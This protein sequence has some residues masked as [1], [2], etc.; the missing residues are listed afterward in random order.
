MVSPRTFPLFLLPYPS[1]LNPFQHESPT[2]GD[3]NVLSS[4][5]F[6]YGSSLHRRYQ[7]ITP[8]YQSTD[9]CIVLVLSV[10][11]PYF[12]PS[13]SRRDLSGFPRGHDDWRPKLHQGQFKILRLSRWRRWW[14]DSDPC[15]PHSW[16]DALP[17]APSDG[18]QVES[19]AGCDSV[20]AISAIL[21]STPSTTSR[22]SVRLRI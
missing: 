11:N 2:S 10:W 1:L 6:Q 8:P 4:A 13:C 21:T 3:P 9:T 12:R 5:S 17:A 18:S 20:E 7:W 19:P 22:S 16:K 14:S 15:A